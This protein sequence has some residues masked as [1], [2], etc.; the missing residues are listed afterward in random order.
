MATGRIK[1]IGEFHTG[2]MHVI[3]SQAIPMLSN[4]FT[5]NA[6]EL[7]K[8]KKTLKQQSRELEQ[9]Y[10]LKVSC[11]VLTELKKGKRYKTGWLLIMSLKDYWLRN[12]V[13]L[14]IEDIK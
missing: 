11:N 2:Q 4:F 12:G 14:Y 6:Q 1:D 7:K 9:M 10:G 3:Q 8:I 5:R 13:N